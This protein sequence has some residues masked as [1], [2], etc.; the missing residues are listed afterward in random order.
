MSFLRLSPARTDTLSLMFGPVID[1]H[2]DPILRGVSRSI[3][4]TLKVAP[5]ATRR[6]LGVA[7]LFC[8]AADTIADTKLLS[9]ESR[10]DDLRRFRSQFEAE[11]HQEEEVRSISERVGGPQAIPQEQAL[12]ARLGECFEVFSQLDSQDRALVRKLVTTLTRGMEMDLEHF[13][14]EESG[15]VA[16]LLSEADLD[17]YTYY[18]AGCVGEFWTDLQAAHLR[19][20]SVWDLSSMREK[21]IRFGKGLQMT[22]ILRDVDCDLAIGRSYFPESR[23][24]EAGIRVE[25]IHRGQG[26]ERLKPILVEYLKLTLRYYRDGWE[27]TLAIP[28]SLPRLRLACAWP[29]LI[30]L[31][32][33][34]RLSRSTDPYAPGTLHKV[35]R[36]EVYSVLCRSASCVFSNRA[37]E[38]LYGGLEGEVKLALEKS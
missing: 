14:P 19:S 12:L 15:E 6:Q 3:F 11:E 30:G 16:S 27:Y 29:L 28:R 9:R 18:V 20:L 31:R 37:L 32:T 4:L 36:A 35:P 34:A 23:L 38:R 25:D 2:L 5:A 13:P 26:R 8:R 7:Y 33:L 21:G 10:L 22:N 24:V 1:N 17:L